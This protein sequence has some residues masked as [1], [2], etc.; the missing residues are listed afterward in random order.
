MHTSKLWL[1][2]IH[3][4]SEIVEVQN[5]S[6]RNSKK[7]ISVPVYYE[8]M[9]YWASAK[10]KYLQHLESNLRVVACEQKTSLDA[11]LSQ[12]GTNTTWTNFKNKLLQLV[13]W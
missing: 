7:R 12:P 11:D 5:I 1:N 3:G 6:S 13:N 10:N 4:I 9:P 8:S 2:N